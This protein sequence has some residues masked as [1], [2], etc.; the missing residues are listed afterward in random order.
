MVCIPIMPVTT[1][2]VIALNMFGTRKRK[3]H[4]PEAFRSLK[5]KLR[6]NKI[7]RMII[8]FIDG[9]FLG[10]NILLE[11]K[12]ANYLNDGIIVFE[13]RKQCL[14][15]V[16]QQLFHLDTFTVRLHEPY[17]GYQ[18]FLVAP[19]VTCRPTN[20]DHPDKI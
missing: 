4:F 19:F 8:M 6:A 11:I 9:M 18:R 16:S 10:R 3:T 7:S 13:A 1:D 20:H 12:L 14:Y 17:P 5:W 2:D 15:C